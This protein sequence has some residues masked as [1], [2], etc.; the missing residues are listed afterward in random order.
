VAVT[1]MWGLAAGGDA[2]DTP[3]EAP[4]GDLDR[5]G[6]RRR[7]VSTRAALFVHVSDGLNLEHGVFVKS[8][9]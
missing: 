3:A 4:A 8:C 2:S 1:L 7:E 5:V 6:W 9:G